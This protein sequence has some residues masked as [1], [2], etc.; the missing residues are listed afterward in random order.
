MK[1]AI[2]RA[3][4]LLLPK[5]LHHLT[6]GRQD[7]RSIELTEIDIEKDVIC[8]PCGHS[9]NDTITGTA[10]VHWLHK[11]GW[12]L[13]D[14]KV[15]CALW[16]NRDHLPIAWQREVMRRPSSIYFDGTELYSK[17]NPEHSNNIY[18]PYIFWSSRTTA[19]TID[20]SH[21][22]APRDFRDATLVIKKR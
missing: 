7:L 17:N 4:P 15:V 2:D 22:A 16:E 9:K 14:I 12:I 21:I 3:R 8:V 10:L 5:E 19:W 11:E 1:I 13:P 18:T 20:Y 6:S